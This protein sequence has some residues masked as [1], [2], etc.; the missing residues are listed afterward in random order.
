MKII[1]KF[2]I[3]A[4]EISNRPEDP[5]GANVQFPMVAPVFQIVRS[6]ARYRT[7]R[8]FYKSQ[9]NTRKNAG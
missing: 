4:Q 7:A 9:D 5:I 1:R 2:S 6:K 8:R 3:Y